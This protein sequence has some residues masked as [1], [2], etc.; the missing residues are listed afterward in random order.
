MTLLGLI[1]APLMLAFTWRYCPD[2]DLALVWDYLFRWREDLVTK[3][4]SADFYPVESHTTEIIDYRVSNAVI[5]AYLISQV[6]TCLILLFLFD[7]VAFVIQRNQHLTSNEQREEKAQFLN[8][9]RADIEKLHTA[10]DGEEA[11]ASMFDET[12][13]S[14]VSVLVKYSQSITAWAKK[15][16]SLKILMFVLGLLW[17]VTSNVIW[18]LLV[19]LWIWFRD[20]VRLLWHLTYVYVDEV[21][22]AGGYMDSPE[23]RLAGGVC[24][25]LVSIPIAMII[26]GFLY[27]APTVWLESMVHSIQSP[28]YQWWVWQ[29]TKEAKNDHGLMGS[30]DILLQSFMQVGRAAFFCF[31]ALVI[32]QIKPAYIQFL[33]DCNYWYK[34]IFPDP[35]VPEGPFFWS[36][37]RWFFNPEWN[38]PERVVYWPPNTNNRV[39]IGPGRNPLPIFVPDEWTNS[40]F[41]Y[42]ER[43]D[44]CFLLE[45]L[46]LLCL[47]S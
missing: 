45:A 9:L 5:M 3:R 47:L 20:W 27:V 15:S 18:P 32:R 21:T 19:F 42:R 17:K 28:K 2:V 25:L 8:T 46:F 34:E 33:H 30:G 35:H 39:T 43:S 44:S 7:L 11:R 38:L 13:D 6:V 22:R 16:I 24:L 40:H 26:L 23:L 10:P 31:D 14:L 41:R 12:L 29:T 1:I 4:S 36:R 37:H